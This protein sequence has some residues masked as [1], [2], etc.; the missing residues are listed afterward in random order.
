MTNIDDRHKELMRTP[1]TPD[2]RAWLP[3]W[4]SIMSA[5]PPRAFRHHSPPFA[6]AQRRQVCGIDCTRFPDIHCGAAYSW[7]TWL[8]DLACIL[9]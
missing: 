6:Q 3:F 1:A 4:D 9:V 8:L 5:R 7:Y 2:A